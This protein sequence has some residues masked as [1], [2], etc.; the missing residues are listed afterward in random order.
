MTMRKSI[1]KVISALI[2]LL[3]FSTTLNSQSCYELVWNEEFNYTGLPDSTKWTHEVGA[4]GWGNNEWQYYTEKRLEN[5]RVENGNL[6]IEARKESY[7]GSNYTSA[8]LITY[9]NGHYWKY[10]KIEARMKLPYGQGIWPAFWMLGKNFFEGT[11]WPACGEIDIMEMV[12]GGEGRDDVVHGTVHWADNGGNYASYGD[13]YQ[14]SSGI[15]ADNF[16]VFSIEWN[17]SSIKWFIDGIQYHVIDITPGALSEFH[18]EFFLILNIAV[19]GNWPGYPDATTVFPQQMQVDYI[20]VYQLNETPGMNGPEEVLKAQSNIQFSTVESGDFTYNWIV[21]G[22][23][24]IVSGQG[25]SSVV[26]D[27]GCSADS[28]KCEL[29]TNCNT[30]TIGYKVEIKEPEIVGQQYVLEN[31]SDLVFQIEP[32]K[33]AAYSWS[34]SDGVTLNSPEDSNAVNVTWNNQDGMV[35]VNFSDDC[36]SHSDSLE[37]YTLRQLPYP[38]PDQPHVI[39][40]TIESTH[41]DIGG[42]GISYHDFEP[43]NKGNGSRQD[44]GVDTEPNDGSENIGWIEPGEWVEYTV[45]VAETGFY[46]LELRVASLYGGGELDLLFNGE[47]KTGSITVPNTGSWTSF[48]SLDVDPF[49]LYDTDTLMR[50]EFSK[51]QFNLGKLNYSSITNTS[52]MEAEPNTVNVYPS[53]VS[54]Y[55]F[56]Q[57]ISS[58]HSYTIFDMMG[59]NVKSGT[60]YPN[61]SISLTDL[62]AG[63][64]IMQVTSPENE[65]TTKKIIKVIH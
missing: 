29:Q 25:T 14:L 4:S 65:V 55:I 39:P 53:L 31:Q 54:E 36:G 26:V 27:W 48:V 21:P 2:F 33:N 59:R 37:V 7:E 20:R 44:E 50:I 45:D 47:N 11:G 6:I 30:Y 23:A 62:G 19:G 24:N 22:D 42:E 28:I 49:L 52:N 1:A 17:S 38:N 40:G 34:F 10:G 41:Y 58:E 64:Y 9:Q 57:N 46:A 61:Q 35:I 63:S 56:I 51:G 32:T 5:S 18:Q 16:H 3:V 8:R 15:L 60:A 13:K 43:E 12:G